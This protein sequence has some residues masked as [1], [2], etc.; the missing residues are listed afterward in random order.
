MTPTDKDNPQEVAG[1]GPLVPIAYDSDEVIE[2][3]EDS[4]NPLGKSVDMWKQ[5]GEYFMNAGKTANIEPDDGIITA[6]AKRA[7]NYYTGMSLAALTG[8]EA[9]YQSAASLITNVALPGMSDEQEK[10]LQ[11][12][13]FGMPDA[14]LGKANLGRVDALGD[15]AENAFKG[16]RAQ[17]SELLDNMSTNTLGSNLGQAFASKIPEG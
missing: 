7:N 9:V 3:N 6:G 15:A 8:A 11:R 14:F 12:D 2:V 13:V 1:T 5:A 16:V 17:G 4:F 10:R